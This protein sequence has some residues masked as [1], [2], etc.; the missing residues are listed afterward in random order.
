MGDVGRATNAPEASCIDPRPS[1]LHHTPGF[2]GS[3]YGGGAAG[4]VVWFI[5]SIIPSELFETYRKEQSQGD[6]NEDLT[7]NIP[8]KKSCQY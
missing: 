7:R 6:H 5:V 3:D 8:V 1:Y 4:L 2:F